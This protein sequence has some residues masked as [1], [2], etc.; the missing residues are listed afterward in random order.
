MVKKTHLGLAAVALTLLVVLV[1]F[2]GC[3]GTTP[4]STTPAI[5]AAPSA[6]TPAEQ[7]KLV[8]ATTTSLYDTGLLNYLQPKFEAQNRIKLLIT[9]QGTGKAIELARRGDADLLLVHSPAQELAFVNSGNGINRRSFA[10][11]SFEIVGPADD[12]AGIAKMTPEWAFTTILLKGTNKTANVYFVSRGDGS[13][14]Q[15]AEINVWKGAGY[16]YTTQVEKSGTWYIEA[17][18]GMG[19]TLRMADEKGAY[20]LTDEGTFLS[21]KNNLAIVPVITNG[22]SLLNIYSVMTVY[23]D[24]QPAEKI[25][26]ANTFINF[27][28]SPQTQADIGSYG[29]DKYGKALFNPMSV[30]QPDTTAGWIGDYSTP[31]TALTPPAPAANATAAVTAAASTTAAT[32]KTT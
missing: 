21:Y 1:G 18:K 5:T 13:G 17:G 14:T 3:T 26:M 30:S 27:L 20:T 16:N 11:N 4:A 23:N 2:S 22:K 31:A 24:E 25:K 12:P 7:Q 15:T 10:W 9:S 32:G 28:T 29:S 19:E 6:T 8:I